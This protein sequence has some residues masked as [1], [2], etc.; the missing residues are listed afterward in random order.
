MAGGGKLTERIGSVSAGGNVKCD[1][2]LHQML[3]PNAVI[4]ANLDNELGKLAAAFDVRQSSISDKGA[5]RRANKLHSVSTPRFFT[6]HVS[7]LRQLIKL[8]PELLMI[9]FRHSFFRQS[10]TIP[11]CWLTIQI[12]SE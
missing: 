3:I 5:K 12:H 9:G 2:Q 4:L 8:S 6:S 11:V 10:G 7:H 1:D